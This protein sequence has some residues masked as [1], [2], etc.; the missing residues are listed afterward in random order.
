MSVVDLFTESQSATREESGRVIHTIVLR[1]GSK[2]TGELVCG[3]R[4]GSG[5]MVWA[6]GMSY[7][8]E[9]S[10]NAAT[11]KG[12]LQWPDGSEY[13]GE[14][15]QGRR[16]GRGV[17]IS[18]LGKYA[19][20]W[21]DGFRH[22]LG[23]Q[24]S[25]E[26]VFCGEW[27][28]GKRHGWGNARF[29]TGNHYE[30]SWKNDEMSGFG[31]MAWITSSVT[32]PP[33]IADDPF[34]T[35][36]HGGGRGTPQPVN[37]SANIGSV[38]PGPLGPYTPSVG[39]TDSSLEKYVGFWRHSK[40]HGRGEHV[41]LFHDGAAIDNPF[42][43]VN[44]YVGEFADGLRH[45]CGIQV[46]ANGAVFEGRWSGNDKTGEGVVCQPDGRVLKATFKHDVLQRTDEEKRSPPPEQDTRLEDIASHAESADLLGMLQ[47]YKPAL[48]HLFA[49]Y[50]ASCTPGNS[51][52]ALDRALS[53]ESSIP[54]PDFLFHPSLAYVVPPAGL[55]KQKRNKWLCNRACENHLAVVQ[56]IAKACA[57]VYGGSS[58]AHLDMEESMQN[59]DATVAVSKATGTHK[60][61]DMPAITEGPSKIP[62]QTSITVAQFER[63]LQDAGVLTSSLTVADLRGTIW[64]VVVR[65]PYHRVAPRRSIGLFIRPEDCPQAHLSFTS[66]VEALV[67]VAHRTLSG[68]GP[69][70]TSVAY[71]RFTI[72]EET[73]L[74]LDTYLAPLSD[75]L[76]LAEGTGE[77]RDLRI[78]PYNPIS[79]GNQTMQ[80]L[81]RQALRSVREVRKAKSV[82]EET[83]S[84]DASVARD[85][86]D[87]LAE[88]LG[89]VGAREVVTL[90][91]DTLER[92]PIYHDA[93]SLSLLI[94]TARGRRMFCGLEGH[95]ADGLTQS[96]SRQAW[97]RELSVKGVR[98]TPQVLLSMSVVA[99]AVEAVVVEL[100]TLFEHLQ[101]DRFGLCT[102]LDV[103][104]LLAIAGFVRLGPPAK[105][106][107]VIRV[108]PPPPKV[109]PV[110]PKGRRSKSGSPPPRKGSSP[111]AAVSPSK[112]GVKKGKRAEPTPAEAAAEKERA[113]VAAIRGERRQNLYRIADMIPKGPQTSIPRTGMSHAD[114]V[115][116]LLAHCYYTLIDGGEVRTLTPTPRVGASLIPESIAALGRLSTMLEEAVSLHD[117]HVRTMED[118]VKSVMPPDRRC[119]VNQ[120]ELLA[121]QIPLTLDDFVSAM[122]VA[123]AVGL[124]DL[125][126]TPVD[127]ANQLKMCCSD[128]CDVSLRAHQGELH[129]TSSLPLAPIALPS[130]L[131]PV[132]AKPPGDIKKKR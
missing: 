101:R 75:G 33:S 36:S 67:R 62:V 122:V 13:C 70:A 58:W 49:A 23:V 10:D 5:T 8:G 115:H 59:M 78:D 63:L 102:L 56:E 126:M 105:P 91:P 18:E 114:L 107:R 4:H 26:G 118:R 97:Y 48:K 51:A 37:A 32:A 31:T 66:F 65:D 35:S 72:V 30:G 128:L 50:S 131:L 42:Q 94:L 120:R 47:N 16:H 112:G 93:T 103:A 6:D 69:W 24:A 15:V 116:N 108:P 11:G 71:Q 22:G 99:Q 38:H 106:R 68:D 121:G 96:A 127:A 57:R 90:G 19:G 29:P 1:D 80:E 52:Q 44:H 73:R 98:V 64:P 123:F 129:P 25:E 130:D 53:N 125:H 14:F 40:P 41:I 28:D 2:Y 109:E 61:F 95:M 9:W 55:S 86:G 46:Y 88:A 34:A 27:L 3:R 132:K 20:D 84:M 124:K 60:D 21:R 74:F 111:A 76:R 45:G 92:V 117:D 119:A 89:E 77:L 39:T 12:V 54:D 113:R 83:D 43:T 110:D 7:R 100:A 87:A 81:K 85:D 82:V 104:N 17:F 79:S